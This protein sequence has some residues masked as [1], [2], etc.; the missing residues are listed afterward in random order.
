MNVNRALALAQQAVPVIPCNPLNKSPLIAKKEG[1][2]GY[3]DATTDTAIIRN[4]WRRWP[5]ALIGVPTGPR[6]VVV[7]CDLQHPE[8]RKWLAS[9]ELPETR[10]HFTRSGGRHVL[11]QPH[12]KVGCSTGKIWPHIDTRGQGGYIIWWPA[13]GFEVINGS[14]LAPVPDWII[15]KLNPSAPSPKPIAITIDHTS[16]PILRDHKLRGILRTI[17]TSQNGTRNSRTFWAACRLAEM[18]RDNAI[19]YDAA[20]R[21]V[22]DAAIHVGLPEREAERST[23]SAFETI[24]IK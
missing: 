12:E 2:N 9:A 22:V 14:I 19:S 1:G 7:D 11:F 4:W 23:Q 5:N 16:S 13:G 3:K 20:K 21:L 18:V 15:K 24:G 8:A 17:V 10:T 6:F